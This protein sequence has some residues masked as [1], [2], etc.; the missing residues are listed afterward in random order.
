MGTN[1]EIAK[2]VLILPILLTASY[3]ANILTIKKKKL[4][5][6]F[7]FCVICF[8]GFLNFYTKTQLTRTGTPAKHMYFPQID[9]HADPENIFVRIL[10]EN[11]Q[12]GM[13]GLSSYLTQGYYALDLALQEPFIPMFGV[14]NSMF[15]SR[16]V[17]RLLINT[18]LEDF[19]YP[20]RIERYG[21][22]S[23]HLWSSI[24]TWLASDFSFVG[25]IFIV[26]IIGRLFALSWI[27]TLR[28]N[29]PFAVVIFSYFTL[30][31]FYF[32]ANNIVMQDGESLFSFF[33]I[34]L[35]WIFSSK[36]IR[37]GSFIKKPHK[38]F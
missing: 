8:F 1:K 37:L 5:I 23:E 4:I 30:M 6:M 32:P 10:P 33:V 18:N 17:S 31:L 13:I 27:D 14:G 35:F 3:L 25:T 16:Q 36:R 21:W 19:S 20:A 2:I 22:D 15:L 34:F 11:Y 7:I 12:I 9:M 28:G 24:Y 38:S 26:F 29:N